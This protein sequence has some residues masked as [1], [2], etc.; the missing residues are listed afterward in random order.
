MMLC[1]SYGL[2]VFTGL[3]KIPELYSELTLQA[4]HTG[5]DEKN[6]PKK[7]HSFN[8]LHHIALTQTF[9]ETWL[10][11]LLAQFGKNM[12]LFIL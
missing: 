2:F 5:Q 9:E 1:W 3:Y 7:M 10:T 8:V 4:L 12:S 11:F 6:V